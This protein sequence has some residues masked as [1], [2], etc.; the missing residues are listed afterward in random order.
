MAE[1]DAIWEQAYVGLLIHCQH[2]G[3]G[4]VLERCL[5]EE[6]TEPVE[7]WADVMADQARSDGWEIVID[8]RVECGRHHVALRP[9]SGRLADYV[10][11]R[12]WSFYPTYSP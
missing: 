11:L 2:P 8:G 1:H 7:G 10:T 9:I 3:C 6:A 4:E 5:T 12:S